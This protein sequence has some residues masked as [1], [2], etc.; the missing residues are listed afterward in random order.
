MNEEALVRVVS[1]ER[2]LRSMLLLNAM[3]MIAVLSMIVFSCR[4]ARSEGEQPLRVSEVDVVD[5]QGVIRARLGG[6][7]PDAVING[8]RTPRGSKAA[9]LMLYDDTGQ[10]RGGYV[11]FSPG[12]MV[13]LTLDSRFGQTGLLV[14]GPEGETA[15]TMWLG[16]DRV[17]MRVDGETGPSIHAS[18]ANEV[19]FHV[20]PIANF[21]K[22]S[23]CGELRDALKQASREQVLQACRARLS[24]EACQACLGA[25]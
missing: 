16:N 17:E 6:D 2:R 5:G 19:A 7:L 18:R 14:A 24:E 25:K 10:E 12:R 3:L 23:G 22:T 9:G 11:T 13:A 8:K 4:T 21:E 15:L 20:P 1:L